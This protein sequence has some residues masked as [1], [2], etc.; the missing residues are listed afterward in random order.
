[1]SV[2]RVLAGS[3][4]SAN[5]KAPQDRS[6]RRGCMRALHFR[7]PDQQ[8]GWP[9][10]DYTRADCIGGRTPCRPS[11]TVATWPWRSGCAPGAVAG[12]ETGVPGAGGVAAGAGDGTGSEP[13]GAPGPAATVAWTAS[14]SRSLSFIVSASLAG[15]SSWPA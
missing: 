5:A 14:A 2:V 4:V 11:G 1:G 15:L 7:S 3:P 6:I 10:S 12:G 8:E 9:A 13:A